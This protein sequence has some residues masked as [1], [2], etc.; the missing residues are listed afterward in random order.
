MVLTPITIRLPREQRYWLLY[1]PLDDRGAAL[2][3]VPRAAHLPV[4][5]FLPRLNLHFQ[6]VLQRRKGR[7][8]RSSCTV[9]I[10]RLGPSVSRVSHD[11]PISASPE[12]SI[13]GIVRGNRRY[14]ECRA[15]PGSSAPMKNSVTEP[16]GPDAVL[17]SELHNQSHAGEASRAGPPERCDTP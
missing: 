9:R 4:K 11:C 13:G 6:S 3:V 1:V 5:F 7:D 15:S 8:L 16:L 14:P 2:L 17:V 10:V 12:T